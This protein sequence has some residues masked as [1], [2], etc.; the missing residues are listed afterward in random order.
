VVSK[1]GFTIAVVA[2]TVGV[3][4]GAPG[5]RSGSSVNANVVACDGAV[6]CWLAEIFVPRAWLEPQKAL[7]VQ[8]VANAKDLK[9]IAIASGERGNS[10][11]PPDAIKL[12]LDKAE[13]VAGITSIPLAIAGGLDPDRYVGVLRVAGSDLPPTEVPVDLNIRRGPVTA[14]LWLL[15]GIL[16]GL[17]FKWW[18]ERGQRFARAANELDDLTALVA[19]ASPATREILEGML[20][21]ARE[22]KARQQLDRLDEALANVESRRAMLAAL[23][24]LATIPG[25]QPEIARIR[26]MILRR[27]D[28]EAKAAIAALEAKANAKPPGGLESIA[29]PKLGEPGTPEQK[30]SPPKPSSLKRAWLWS[31]QHLVG[32]LL[33]CIVIGAAL[34]LGLKA[35]YIDGGATY[36]A[37]PFFDGIALFVWGL[38]AE[39]STRTFGELGRVLAL[40][41]PAPPAAPPAPKPTPAAKAVVALPEDVVIRRK[42]G[43]PEVAATPW[44][45]TALKLADLPNLGGVRVGVIDTGVVTNHPQLADVVVE[46]VRDGDGLD[47][48]GHG[49]CMVGIVVGMAK[50]AVVSIRALDSQ[51]KG[52]AEDLAAGIRK[53]IELACDVISIS[54]GQR[55]S[56]PVLEEAIEAARAAGI[57][58][59]SA[60]R[61]ENPKGAAYPARLA[62]V[63]AVTPSTKVGKLRY[64]DSPTWVCIG[65]PGE[66][67]PT[68]SP[69]GDAEIDG[70]SPATAVVAGVCARLLG[71]CSGEKRREL[72]SRLDVV[73]RDTRNPERI[74]DAVSAAKKL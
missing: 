16:V 33:R 51:G 24:R 4:F 3:S 47:T 36:G 57:V 21:E 18:T 45:H 27:Q 71:T 9:A 38:G 50:A 41:A 64:P 59:V 25:N 10:A 30:P 72:G 54:A 62:G 58:V 1:L 39:V 15:F 13:P 17:A 8:E 61:R 5:V 46:D 20:A 29:A 6:D 26:S 49:T 55:E 53:A 60:I 48:N 32:P 73:L 31:A 44:H 74:I 67:I 37:S 23:D 68:I 2:F 40:R 22:A 65:A 35:L 42:V 7:V 69:T 56:A 66:A 28:N 14:I 52:T 70:S 12:V 43:G 63:I 11:L 34:V 19:A